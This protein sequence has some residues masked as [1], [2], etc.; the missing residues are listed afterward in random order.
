MSRTRVDGFLETKG[1][2]RDFPLHRGPVLWTLRPSPNR[3]IITA[4]LRRLY[5][6]FELRLNSSRGNGEVSVL[7]GVRSPEPIVCVN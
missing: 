5:Q 3:L 1:S 6:P 7:P 4:G 2:I